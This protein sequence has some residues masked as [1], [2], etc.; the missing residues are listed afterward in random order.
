MQSTVLSH[1]GWE[2]TE[3]GR[4]K[5]GYVSM[6]PDTELLLAVDTRCDGQDIGSHVALGIG[7]LKSYEGMG[8]ARIDCIEGCECGPEDVDGHWSHESSQNDMNK[9]VVSMAERCVLRVTNTNRSSSG[10]H[11]FKLTSLILC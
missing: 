1:A 4:G 7:N 10:N 3:E 5:W 8:I 2:W 9:L 6:A 11:K